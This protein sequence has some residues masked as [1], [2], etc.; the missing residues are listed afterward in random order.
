[1]DKTLLGKSSRPPAPPT[2][3]LIRPPPPL[4]RRQQPEL[5]ARLP[6]DRRRQARRWL[7][8][9]REAKPESCFRSKQTG[10]RPSGL[11]SLDPFSARRTRGVRL[12]LWRAEPFI[13]MTILDLVEAIPRVRRTGSRSTASPTGR[14]LAQREGR[15]RQLQRS[16]GRLARAST[17]CTSQTRMNSLPRAYTV[18]SPSEL[19]FT[20]RP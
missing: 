4:H 13:A 12:A 6:P 14:L 8:C 9:T 7:R 2:C 15:G 11:F 17:R 19:I 18:M 3:R 1:M 10:S 20:A 16:V 5:R